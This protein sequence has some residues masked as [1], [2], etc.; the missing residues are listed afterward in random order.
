VIEIRIE[1]FSFG[2]IN[3]ERRFK[4]ISSRNIINVIDRSGSHSDFREIGGPNS[5]IGSF[6]LILRVV[7]RID[8][9]RNDSISFVPFL[10]I[11][12]FEVVV[13]GVDSEII[14]NKRS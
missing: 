10:I 12:L 3:T 8:S 11:I 4:V 14:G 7:R 5:S 2:N 9:V 1:S 6:S 13:G